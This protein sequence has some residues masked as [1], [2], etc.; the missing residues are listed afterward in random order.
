MIVKADFIALAAELEKEALKFFEEDLYRINIK[1]TKG[2]HKW[3][4][5]YTLKRLN[6]T[7][8]LKNL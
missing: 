7:D 3:P 6:D 5:D 8:L 2:H 4:Q 1:T